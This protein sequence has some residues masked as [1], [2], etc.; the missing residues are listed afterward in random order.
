MAAEA[1]G[2]LAVDIPLDLKAEIK[3][4]AAIERRLL[5]EVIA[6]ALSKYLKD[7]RRKK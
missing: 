5:K 1:E 7:A 3:I 4:Q 6:D 2:R